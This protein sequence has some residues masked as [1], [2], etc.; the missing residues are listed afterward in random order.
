MIEPDVTRLSPNFSASPPTAKLVVIHST[1]SGK[2][3]NPTEF[4]GTLNWF[5]RN[6]SQVSSHW[7]IG[8][9]GSK[10]RVVADGQQAWHAGEHNVGWGIELEQ[11]VSDDGFTQKQ[12]AALT[13]VCAGYVMDF[14]VPPVHTLDASQAGFIG[15]EETRQ[16]KRVGKSDPGTKFVWDSFIEALRKKVAPS[17]DGPEKALEQFSAAEIAWACTN[18]QS[19]ALAEVVFPNDPALLHIEKMHPEHLDLIEALVKEARRRQR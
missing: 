18:L 10:A 1:R 11:G 15:H 3:N 5:A 7:V 19:Y 4:E 17:P 6:D 12:L 16:G 13:E 8:R 14:G 2:S 9:D